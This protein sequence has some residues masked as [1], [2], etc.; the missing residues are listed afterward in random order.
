MIK[1]LQKFQK[2]IGYSFKDQ[3]ILKQALVHPSYSG[4]MHMCRYES[5]QR[6]EF[7]G[8]AVL[9]L[10]ISE[11]LYHEHPR[12]EEGELTRK[13]SSLVFETALDVCARSIDLGDYLYL[14][15]GED[16]GSGRN[17]PSIL[18]DA[19]EAVIGAIYLDGGFDE[20]RRFI[21]TFVINNVD[22]MSLLRDGK[23]LIQKY[24]QS[25]HES[26]LRYEV[27]E[28]AAPGHAERFRARLFIN[29][30][31][32]SEGTGQSKKSAEQNAAVAAC[33]ILNISNVS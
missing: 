1:D 26:D 4:E 24:V 14:G 27:D 12:V 10:A 22:E 23:S 7:L 11:Y 2:T 9:E 3:S 17:K 5:N 25:M 29:D 21:K 13:R 16:A 32:Y 33:R 30:K 8:D 18:S 15:K 28:I 6:L 19:F 31:L 20:A